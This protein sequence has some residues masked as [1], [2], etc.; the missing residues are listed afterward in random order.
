MS[1]EQ[2]IL[3]VDDEPDILSLL[4]YNLK[5]KG[6][7]VETATNGIEAIEK[8]K[9]F[10]PHLILLDVMMPEMDGIETCEKIRVTPGLEGITIAFLTALNEDYAEITGFNAGADDFINKPIKPHVLLSRVKALL[11][12]NSGAS[13]NDL[14]N[15]EAG[16]I[17]FD[18][19]RYIVIQ[20]GKEF[21]IP[22]KEFELLTL[23]MSKPNKV[24][25]RDEIMNKIWGEEVVVGDRTIDVHIRKLREK[26]GE[27][28]IDTV[29][30]VGYKFTV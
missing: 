11:R 27:N 8:A 10:L 7:S 29:K 15:I 20:N 18:K 22:R 4:E 30:G 12:R 2:R 17:I 3:L 24:F 23:L 26:I 25:T 14:E 16:G 6:Y 28:L 21:S 1:S 13:I 5:A 9:S 19:E